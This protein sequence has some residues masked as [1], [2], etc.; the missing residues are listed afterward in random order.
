MLTRLVLSRPCLLLLLLLHPQQILTHWIFQRF[1]FPGQMTSAHP[2]PPPTQTHWAITLHTPL[3]L[4]LLAQ[5]PV[6]LLLLPFKFLTSLSIRRV[7]TAHTESWVCHTLTLHEHMA[8]GPLDTDSLPSRH[9]PTTHNTVC[10]IGRAL[11]RSR[12]VP[13]AFLKILLAPGPGTAIL[14]H[15]AATHR[16]Q[17][18]PLPHLSPPDTQVSLPMVVRRV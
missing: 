3:L 10:L 18:H 17:H 14:F 13:L 15:S 1:L 9:H 12:V 16:H 2:H 5:Q 4:L 6:T 8:S 11:L 7:N